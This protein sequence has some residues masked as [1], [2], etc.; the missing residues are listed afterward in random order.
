MEFNLKINY[1]LNLDDKEEI[2]T[3]EEKEVLEDQCKER[4]FN[5][6]NDGYTSGELVESLN[7]ETFYGWWN[8]N[9]ERV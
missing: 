8:L 3:F 7:E 2:L 1:H 6:I 5:Q 4:I 9:T